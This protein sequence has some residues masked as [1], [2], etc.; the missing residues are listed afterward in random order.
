MSLLD[1]AHSLLTVVAAFIVG[2]LVGRITGIASDPRRAEERRR[3]ERAAAISAADHAARLSPDARREIESLIAE[4]HIIE[5]IRV[6]RA[7]LNLDLK[8]ARDA[9]EHLRA[10][11]SRGARA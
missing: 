5:A 4:D 1:P 2:V 3:R 11:V 10:K 7:D 8:D 6:C 9:I